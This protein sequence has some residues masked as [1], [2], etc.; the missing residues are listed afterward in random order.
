[1]DM[2][3]FQTKAKGQVISEHIKGPLL[4]VTR[5]PLVRVLDRS[6]ETLGL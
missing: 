3:A 1:M 4:A 6:V 5:S 2:P